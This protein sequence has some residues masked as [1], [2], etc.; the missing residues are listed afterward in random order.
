MKNSIFALIAAA[1]LLTGCGRIESNNVGLR[2][3]FSGATSEHIETQGFYTAFVGHVDQY[4]LKEV[5]INLEN[6]QPKAKDNLSLN[7]LDVTVFYQV[8]SGPNVRTL[9]LKRTGQSS[10]PDHESFC[11][12]AYN[13]VASIARSEIADAVSKHDSLTIHTQR[14]V[15]EGEVKTAIQASVDAADPGMIKITKVV[16]RQIKTDPTVENSIRAVVAKSKELEAATL[17]VQVAEKN[18][19][20]VAKTANTLTPGFLT[21]EYNLA[22]MEFAKHGGTVILDGSSS[23]KMINVPAK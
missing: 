22:L 17:Q 11:Y 20:A 10:C 12:P 18:A 1:V 21:H 7:E 23:G 2:T 15:L 8:T 19:E 14:N 9:A 4:T 3:D 16:V 5:P 6:M 13:Y